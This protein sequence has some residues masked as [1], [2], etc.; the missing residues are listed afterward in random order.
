MSTSIVK[1]PA[2]ASTS[3]PL[4]PKAIKGRGKRP[5]LQRM[6][7]PRYFG[8]GLA[9]VLVL[10]ATV[11]LACGVGY[12]ALDPAVESL[13]DGLWMAFTTA[14]TVGY[15]D[16]VP[17]SRLSRVFSVIV[18]LMGFACLS[19]VTASISAKLV[20]NQERRME[21]DILRDLHAQV[22][23]LRQELAELKAQQAQLLAREPHDT[24]EAPE[25]VKAR[26]RLEKERTGA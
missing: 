25:A 16:V 18:V 19:L 26:D 24:H 10:T 22:R 8:T 6:G 20:G 23:M 3:S 5:W 13:E 21:R 7:Q 17:S 15:G 14:A 9:Q 1:R 11:V 4:P 2:K 12:F